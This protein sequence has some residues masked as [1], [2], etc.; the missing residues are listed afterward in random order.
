[1]TLRS[2]GNGE[3]LGNLR[4]RGRH[5]QCA[6]DWT[7][8]LQSMHSAGF[9]GLLSVSGSL[10]RAYFFKLETQCSKARSRVLQLSITLVPNQ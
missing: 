6:L 2:A 5:H 3:A 7:H 9:G 8:T 4:G 1:M 10:V